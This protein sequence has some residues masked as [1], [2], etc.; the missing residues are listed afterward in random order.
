MEI[1]DLNDNPLLTKLLTD[2]CFRVYEEDAIIDEYHLL[3][4]YY[5]LMKE[6]RLNDLFI[7]EKLI[8]YMNH[9]NEYTG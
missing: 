8:N 1:T 6:N 5:L 2:Y 9:G 3:I 4:E 7:E